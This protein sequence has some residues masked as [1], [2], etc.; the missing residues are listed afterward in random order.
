MVILPLVYLID[1]PR[2]EV[3]AALRLL[4]HELFELLLVVSVVSS[5]S[6]SPLLLLCGSI[7]SLHLCRRDVLRETNSERDRAPLNRVKRK[8]DDVHVELALVVR[9]D[10]ELSW[11]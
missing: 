7:F 11:L 3:R 8:V 10:N 5:L 1:V 6:C 9:S 4:A 2:D